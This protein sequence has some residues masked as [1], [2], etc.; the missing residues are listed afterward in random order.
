MRRNPDKS[1]HEETATRGAAPVVWLPVVAVLGVAATLVFA[2]FSYDSAAGLWQFAGALALCFL[3][4]GYLALRLTGAAGRAAAFPTVVLA[5]V[6]G[7]VIASSL[8][9]ILSLFGA[10][11]VFI[12]VTALAA[13]AALIAAIVQK[14][15]R[16]G[17]PRLRITKSRI[18]FAGLALAIVIYAIPAS[19]T[20][21]R[22]YKDGLRFYGYH[23]MD[24][25]WHLAR[26][27]EIEHTVP[28]QN[29][30]DAGSLLPYHVLYHTAVNVLHHVSGVNFLDI[31]FRLMPVFML[32]LFASML[33]VSVGKI[34]GKKA[35]ALWAP[36]LFFFAGDLGYAFLVR[37]AEAGPAVG[38][39]VRGDVSTGMSGLSAA[40]D[41]AATIRSRGDMY[42]ELSAFRGNT[43]SNIF[44][45]ETTLTSLILLFA[46]LYFL[47][48]YC[49]RG[50]GSSDAGPRR[51]GR[52]GTAILGALCIGAMMQAKAHVGAL[53]LAGLFVAALYVLL[54]KRDFLCAKFLLIAAL[55]AVVFAVPWIAAFKGQD[56]ATF[57]EGAL[58]SRRL[59]EVH[60]DRSLLRGVATAPGLGMVFGELERGAI[61]LVI[62]AW[63]VLIACMFGAR[64][65]GIPFMFAAFGRR[66]GKPIEIMMVCMIVIGVALAHFTKML[67]EDI[68]AA[69]FLT[70]VVLINY[71]GARGMAWL[72]GR[73]S[74][75]VRYAA[76][77]VLALL[78]LPMP[79]FKFVSEMPRYNLYAA[80]SSDE[81]ELY[82][83][84][85][86]E[87]CPEAKVLRR[88][89][90]KML[91]RGESDG[92]TAE[93]I[94]DS[95]LMALAGRRVLGI[96]VK[97]HPASTQAE[98][99]R[100]LAL[101]RKWTDIYN[102]FRTGKRSEALGM[103]RRYGVTHVVLYD[104][105]ELHFDG[106]GALE[107]VFHNTAGRILRVQRENIATVRENATE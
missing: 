92:R 88:F 100:Q 90:S 18:L 82:A 59:V 101:S 57:R 83:R 8:F 26:I 105:E 73:R 62:A 102:F 98:L 33:Y 12:P 56:P 14:R 72:G 106:S 94:G 103:L 40:L 91:L 45:S 34:S 46:G 13:V 1:V 15:G 29:P 104:G 35:V 49:S 97:N 42:Y 30:M 47:N 77:I 75:A 96:Q 68:Y 24:S 22:E 48:E 41:R 2:Y 79:V 58:A 70:G 32:L 5:F 52:Y 20:S 9:Y 10:R 78:M 17:L 51:E 99:E 3:A 93:T 69:H 23:S 66:H 87:S 74:R 89:E 31:Q 67:G 44:W 36:V 50:G 61:P 60:F 81:E 71:F 21:G 86:A 27:M 95:F 4:P 39:I 53:A 107:E 85:R 63:F 37:K 6:L 38:A 11:P 7:L 64:V 19:F 76:P 65:I 25:M 54:V 84:L 55:F 80:V 28:P 43:F 16:M